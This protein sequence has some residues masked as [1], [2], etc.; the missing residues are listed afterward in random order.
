MEF[1]KRPELD[2][3]SLI[4]NNV[5]GLDNDLFM[6]WSPFSRPPV[7]KTILPGGLLIH[8]AQG[9]HPPKGGLPYG[10]NYTALHTSSFSD[11]ISRSILL[12]SSGQKVSMQSGKNGYILVPQF[13]AGIPIGQTQEIQ[14]GVIY[15]ITPTALPTGQIRV[16][17]NC[18]NSLFTEN[19]F[20]KANTSTTTSQ[21]VVQILNDGWI[22]ASG[23]YLAN[24]TT[25]IQG[26]PTWIRKLPII[27][28]FVSALVYTPQTTQTLLLM[29][30]STEQGEYPLDGGFHLD[31]IYNIP[32]SDLPAGIDNLGE[33]RAALA[34][35]IRL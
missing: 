29:K 22:V 2:S 27:G 1:I 6:G 11:L 3:V 24:S 21:T 13:S 19:A 30:F 17:L 4:P 18:N 26:A 23:L 20:V 31:Q 10:L 28:P 34:P 7:N 35:G 32:V 9:L 15:D 25:N 33:S 8:A 12:V 14:T 5:A 16:T